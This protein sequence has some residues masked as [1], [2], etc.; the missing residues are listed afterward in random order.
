MTRR[1]QPCGPANQRGVTLVE[2]MV[3]LVV[4]L[5]LLA[6]MVQLFSSNKQAYR[7]QEA[8]NVVNENSRYV[9]DQLQYDIRM[10][11]HWG[12]VESDTITTVSGMSAVTDDCATN[13]AAVLPAGVFGLDGSTGTP[14]ACIPT[15]DYV[16]N[17]DVL[18][19]R[20]MAPDRVASGSVQDNT[21][22]L[23]S[24]IGRRGMLFQGVNKTSLPSDLLP[25]NWTQTN[26]L[27][28][29]P[30]MATY[31]LRT[32]VY[33]IRPCAS[34][35][36]GTANVCD[37]ADDTTPTLTRFRLQGMNMVEEDVI[38]GVE[39]M[40]LSYGVDTN[41]DRSA[42]VYRNATEV[43]AANQWARVV[44]VKMSLVLRNLARDT[45]FNDTTTYRLYGG[46]AGATVNYTVPAA[47][48]QFRRKVYHST[49]QIRNMNRG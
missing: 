4:G 43:T 44:N 6:G 10:A 42:D 25:A 26:V 34:Q 16:A 37:T 45:T 32:M 22:Y 5:I 49:V 11:D 36:K 27:L 35:A 18:V 19:L 17:T 9:M 40:Q 31:E 47:D 38:A 39:Q 2:M 28:E 41:G 23:R 30:S 13:A 29:D 12:G 33:F 24:A 8:S 20:Y 3:A 46:T 15:A 1:A 21:V 14:V 48:R 7:I